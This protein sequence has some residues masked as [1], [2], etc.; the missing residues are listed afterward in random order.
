MYG[1][2]T[3]NS[4]EIPVHNFVHQEETFMITLNDYLYSGNTVLKILQEYIRDL[5]EDARITH[6]EIDLAHCNF[7]IQIMELLEH[8]DFLPAQSQ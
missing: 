1:V 7:L 3:V 8:N 6:N 4:S 2:N 5:R